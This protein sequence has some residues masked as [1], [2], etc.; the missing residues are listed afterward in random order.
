[1]EGKKLQFED[2]PCTLY[3]R[4]KKEIGKSKI[5]CEFD[6]VFRISCKDK[7]NKNDIDYL[8][9]L[10]PSIKKGLQV[11]I[12]SKFDIKKKYPEFAVRNYL[13]EKIA[14]LEYVFP[15]ILMCLAEPKIFDKGIGAKPDIILAQESHRGTPRH[16]LFIEFKSPK[17]SFTIG[18]K[19]RRISKY[20]SSAL[21]EQARRI[22]YGLNNSKVFY[23]IFR[24]QEVE[25]VW[26]DTAIIMG[27]QAFHGNQ[28]AIPIKGFNPPINKE[29]S[30]EKSDVVLGLKKMLAPLTLL[31]YDSLRRPMMRDILALGGGSI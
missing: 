31:S 23:E 9:E 22:L 11:P 14:L 21:S 25:G 1:M 27:L 10:F 16:Y 4:Y 28:Q 17:A 3:E 8:A 18:G 13:L 15:E 26:V 6:E 5:W 24:R 2:T 29:K 7:W 19:S 20:L 12:S 30:Y